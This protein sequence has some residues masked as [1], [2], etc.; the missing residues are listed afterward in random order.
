MNQSYQASALLTLSP[1]DSWTP[2]ARYDITANS[3]GSPS[4][5]ILFIDSSLPD[6]ATL[7]QSAAIGTEVHLLRSG[8][9]GID[10]ITQMLLGQRGISAIHILSHGASGGVQLGESWLDLQTLPSRV[11][12]LKSWSQSLTDD[13]DI[14][15][16]GCNVGEG[17]NGRDFVKALAQ[18][19]TADIAA[20]NDL[21]GQ[22][23]LRGDWDLEVRSGVIEYDTLR[24][25]SYNYLLPLIQE[26]GLWFGGLKLQPSFPNMTSVG[27]TL[28]FLAAEQNNQ[29]L[30]LWKSD[31]TVSGTVKVTGTNSDVGILFPSSLINFNET[32]YFIASSDF[33]NKGLWKVGSNGAELIK[34]FKSNR[35]DYAGNLIIANNNL[36]F[37]AYTPT[38]G[39]ALWKSDGT[40]SGT[41]IAKDLDPRPVSDPNAIFQPSN[42]RD[43]TSTGSTLYFSGQTDTTGFELWKS[44]GTE[45]GTVL[46]KDIKPGFQDSSISQTTAVRDTLYF[47]ADDGIN[48]TALWKSDGTQAGTIL[49]KDVE[50]GNNNSTI[51]FLTNLN[52]L[53]YFVCDDGV[54]GSELWKSD[55]TEA[56][57]SL[58]R[59]IYPG[60]QGAKPGDLININGTLYFR[61]DNGITGME[62]WKSDGTEAGTVLVKDLHPESRAGD[63]LSAMISGRTDSMPANFFNF[64]GMLYFTATDYEHGRE[65]WRSD[66][67]EAGT[68]LVKDVQ[69]GPR[70]LE[71][72]NFTVSGDKLYFTTFDSFGEKFTLWVERPKILALGGVKVQGNLETLASKGSQTINQWAT[73]LTQGSYPA[74]LRYKV[75]IDRPDLFEQS[76]TI[77]PT[78]QLT[79]TAKP[80]LKL[81][82]VINLKIEV[83]ESDGTVIDH[84][85]NTAQLNFKYRPETLIRNTTTNEVALLYIDRVTQL[86]TQRKLTYG[87]NF[88]ESS[89]QTVKVSQEW[90]ISDTADFNRDGIADLL[91]HNQSGD[92]VSIYMMGDEGQVKAMQ[93]LKGQDGQILRTQNPYWKVIGFADVDRDNILDITWHNSQTDEVGF[94]FM[95]ADGQTV[96]RYDYL[97]DSSGNILKTKNSWQM[98]D[99]AD[100]DGDGDADLLFRLK[101]LNQTAIVRLN[102]TAMVDAQ[103]ITSNADP[104]LEIRGVGDANGDRIP[105][106]YWQTPDNKKILIQSVAFQSG[107]WLTDTFR[108]IESSAK[109][110]GIGDLDLNNTADLLTKDL[111]TNGLTITTI[112][113][114]SINLA[115]NLQ[116]SG[117]TFSFDRLDWQIEQIDDFGDLLPAVPVI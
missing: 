44:D 107:S 64:D 46:L 20:S 90:A 73:D 59:D 68:V 97:R 109:L 23:S 48:G 3:P 37:Q 111:K 24:P 7:S 17:S 81:N 6:V 54:H 55:G 95:G 29:P 8:E 10:Q 103:Y 92:E 14:L 19:T 21:T 33:T 27:N 31:G 75:T 65:I 53:L 15:L 25:D 51:G 106:I 40:E 63:D 83:E 105:D 1:V 22:S 5:S 77:T 108:A 79:Y 85:T 43:F 91:F 61:A 57:T 78:G 93:S 71:L 69:P 86:Q 87:Q 56:G 12:Q 94:W 62:L 26:M 4:R 47:T 67:T 58:V 102:G 84:L 82:A 45:S 76:P 114:D 113:A 41:I 116:D 99:V 16:Y 101:E 52:D 72:S 49:V 110:Q 9:D 80:F 28:Y 88:G 70:S 2:Q 42:F 13:A 36:Y 32:L 112:N 74:G 50:P 39:S 11:A 96:K 115:G 38:E 100:F 35:N 34:D 98:S 89:G 104:S 18:I 66:G 117:A 60:S 30:V